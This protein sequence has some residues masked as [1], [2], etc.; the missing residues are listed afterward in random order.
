[1]KDANYVWADGSY[2]IKTVAWAIVPFKVNKPVVLGDSVYTPSGQYAAIAESEF[3]T[4]SGNFALVTGNYTA[5]ATLKDKANFTWQD[6]TVEDLTLNWKIVPAKVFKPENLKNLIYTG[7]EQTAEIHVS[8][9]CDISGN[10]AK[11]AGKY[12]ATVSLKDSVNYTW[13]DG[14]VAPVT[15]EWNIYTLSLSDGEE[16][17]QNYVAGT[18]LPSPQKE[19]YFFDGWYASPDFSGERIYS[20][21][22]LGEDTVLYAKWSEIPPSGDGE[23]A[24]GNDG[25]PVGA[26]VGIAVAC[27][28]AVAAIAIIIV[29]LGTRSKIKRDI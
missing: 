16:V 24:D 29:G 9:L 21:N 26:I 22:E 12:T 4:L 10:K 14:T 7:S 3:Y 11:D 27:A 5:T 2:G 8:E 6:S 23:P 13:E 20:L 15:V 25:L 1:M 18:P 28:G 17:L 19:N